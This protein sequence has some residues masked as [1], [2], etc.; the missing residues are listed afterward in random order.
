MRVKNLTLVLVLHRNTD[1]GLSR[2]GERGNPK[3]MPKP[4]V[5]RT[6]AFLSSGC[7]FKDP[8]GGLKADSTREFC[9]D[10]VFTDIH[11]HD[12]WLVYK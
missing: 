6:M 1:P 12:Q 5:C 4:G 9:V 8:R 11:T 2:D 3:Q 10:H 7:A